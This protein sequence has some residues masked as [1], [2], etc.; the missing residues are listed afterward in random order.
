[1]A[2]ARVVVGDQNSAEFDALKRSYNSLLLILENIASEV[3]GSAL[4]PA[5]GFAALLAAL[6][7]GV[8]SGGVPG[9][10]HVG[11]GRFLVGVKSTPPIPPRS[12]ETVSTL[13]SMTDS[14]KF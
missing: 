10:A 3:V 2:K 4:T 9:P 6:N 5:E 13:V 14:D 12:A 11:T 1:M 7:T 8:D